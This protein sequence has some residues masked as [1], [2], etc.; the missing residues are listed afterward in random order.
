MELSKWRVYGKAIIMAVALVAV[1]VRSAW[2]GD[3][4]ISAGEGLQM[5][6]VAA[7]AVMTWL[8]PNLPGVK[9]LKPG[10]I[11]VMTVL[12]IVTTTLSNWQVT[13]DEWVN[14][15][16]ALVAAVF[17]IPAPSKSTPELAAARGYR[18]P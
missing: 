7:T 6:T 4:H 3:H 16:I 18:T 15:G 12:T 1:S 2:L 11:G 8:V 17:A 14:V 13:G 9:W 5:A 10:T